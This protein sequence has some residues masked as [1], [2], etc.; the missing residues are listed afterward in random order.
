MKIAFLGD[1]SLSDEYTH[2][3]RKG[4][5]PF[6]KIG[7]YLKSFDY[8]IGNLEC[9]AKG[10][11]GE[12]ELKKPRLKT[13]LETLNYLTDI[14]VNV[15]GLAH[16]HAYDNLKDGFEKTIAFLDSKNIQY[17]GASVNASQA[18]QPL[19][20]EKGGISVCLLNYVSKDTNPN[21]PEDAEVYLNYLEKEKVE[22]DI[23]L[24]KQKYHYVVLF[25]HWGGNMEG[26]KFP[27]WH[28]P[29][30]A[31]DFI[32]AGADL[33]VGNHSHTIQPY[34]M[35]KGKYIFYS[36]GNFCF[37]HYIYFVSKKLIMPKC[38]QKGLMLQI[39]FDKK[40]LHIDNFIVKN[41]HY[42]IK[43]TKVR[44][45]FL[46][47]NLFYKLLFSHYF[48]WKFY[49]V[50]H[51]IFSIISLYN[52]MLFTKHYSLREKVIILRKHISRKK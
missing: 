7:A 14:G 9:L 22:A 5:K 39:Y 13:T 52:R 10:E 11:K 21:L 25:L 8:V 41:K 20:L 40:G 46:L 48:L 26:A 30:E 47:F 28:Q 15:V 23:K 51:N 38:Y 1:I 50:L 49:V 16:N 44:N 35:Y 29:K 6:D 4:A 24:Y 34:E 43:Y 3:Y 32:D 18:K 27:D 42:Q 36:L 12:N 17:L 33:I 37:S 19:I 31:K 45:Y 2:L